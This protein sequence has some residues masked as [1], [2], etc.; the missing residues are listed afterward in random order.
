[1]KQLLLLTLF[2]LLI[3][4]SV[5]AL[6]QTLSAGSHRAEL[7]ALRTGE[8]FDAPI[9]GALGAGTFPAPAAQC[10]FSP[11]LS[12]GA[13][14]SLYVALASPAADKSPLSLQT[15]QAS[16]ASIPAPTVKVGTP[17]LFWGV[18]GALFAS[19][20][21]NAEA[22]YRCPNCT[23][24]PSS[25]H[26]RGITYGAGFSVDIASTLISRHLIGKKHMVWLAP[27][28]ILTAANGFLA[29][30]WAVRIDP[31]THNY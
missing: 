26:R 28:A 29:Y 27:N 5:T 21:A 24:L 7:Q 17:M 19:S 10:D 23:F 6:G 15:E 12:S 31:S 2:F 16:N 9:P 30:H 11:I 1:M 18:T 8:P 25:L 20:I 14:S 3:V 13:S 22:L 4:P